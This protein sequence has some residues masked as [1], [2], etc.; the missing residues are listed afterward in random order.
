M[1]IDL[2]E[3]QIKLA[4]DMH[5][6][7]A[8]MA[9]G[10]ILPPLPVTDE[11]RSEDEARA[12]ELGVQPVER[13]PGETDEKFNVRLGNS[14]KV[15]AMEKEPVDEMVYPSHVDKPASVPVQRKPAPVNAFDD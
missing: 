8:A 11:N 4:R 10:Y 14:P 9:Q 3:D 15:G 5:T 1:A 2:T 6:I 12:Q 13:E 7:H